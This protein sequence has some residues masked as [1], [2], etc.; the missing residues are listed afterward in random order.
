MTEQP[1]PRVHLDLPA[2]V[3]AV[4]FTAAKTG[5]DPRLVE[6]D[7]FCTL[8][9]EQLAGVDA[10]VFKGGTCLAKVHAGFYRLSEDLDFAVATPLDATRGQRRSRI[11]PVKAAFDELARRQPALRIVEPLAGANVSTQYLATVAYAS[12]IT[13][14]D[15]TI[16]I[17]V[18]LREP[19]LVEPLIGAAASILLDPLGG[20]PLA[21]A[22]PVR[23]IALIEAFA[24]KLRA[25]LSRREPAIRDFFD[26]DWA[27]Q[28][29]LLHP[30]SRTLVSLVRSKLAIPGNAAVDVSVAR[31]AA[32]RRQ[33][34]QGL[35]SVLRPAD[36]AAFDLDRAFTVVSKM[37]AKVGMV[38]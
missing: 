11:A 8:V 32:L 18:A 10:L 26:V 7:Y 1:A 35:R 13:R 25:A 16:T 31:L 30:G 17:E 33:T 29:G 4:R 19:L 36:F 27:V 2:F 28:R 23:C 14:R 22:F 6:K 5:F 24:E 20:G 38:R 9:L 37:A 21:E 34:D 12:A 3:E 15:E